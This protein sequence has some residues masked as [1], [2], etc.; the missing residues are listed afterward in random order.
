MDQLPPRLVSTNLHHNTSPPT[1]PQA[2]RLPTNRLLDCLAA[3]PEE[4]V[5]LA[6]L[7]SRRTRLA[8]QRDVQEF[9][10]FVGV[11]TP[12]ELRRV[13]HRAVIAWESRMREVQGL[14]ASTIRRR[15]AAL[16]SLFGHLVRHGVVAAN[17]VR[18]VDR[19]RV[20]RRQGKTLAFSQRQARRILDAPSAATI[21]GLRDRAILAVGLQ[22][23]LRR[24]EIT[25]L[26]VRDLHQNRGF[27]S[28]WVIRKGA[29]QESVA[30]HPQVAQRIRDYL[31]E[32][33][34][35]T[36]P[37]GPLF[38]PC[39]GNGYARIPRRSLHP[40]AVNRIV[41]K[42]VR[43]LRLPSGFSAHSMRA[44]FITTALDNGASLEDVQRDVGH[45]DPATTKLYDRR[46]H[47][48]E[49]SASFFANY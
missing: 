22:V 29:K 41:K 5:W 26:R 44:T 18:D 21:Q 47:N 28:L 36:D 34:H 46:G 15:L 27:D 3:V 23:G 11:R 19:P 6:K 20:S 38:R 40:D 17:P 13:D 14:Q 16:S 7:K 33:G 32:A 12:E 35:S 9:M 8:Y 42:Y 45:A 4:A 49:K 37:D 31:C 48:P 10:A 39:R 30:V 43:Q 25:S 1:S 2:V 24:A